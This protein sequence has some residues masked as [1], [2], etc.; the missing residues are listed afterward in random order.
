VE[1]LPPTMRLWSLQEEFHAFWSKYGSSPVPNIDFAQE[2]V[3]GIFLGAKPN[4]G[5]TVKVQQVRIDADELLIE[6]RL[7][8]PD[9]EMDYAAMIV[10]PHHLLVVKSTASKAQFLILD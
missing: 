9:A 1:E 7:G 5:Y 3:I 8:L 10:F 6:Y 4:P 2:R